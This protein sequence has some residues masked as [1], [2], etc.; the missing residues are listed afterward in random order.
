[1]MKNI[2][3]DNVRLD[4]MGQ[5]PVLI[6]MSVLIGSS[7][8]SICLGYFLKIQEPIMTLSRLKT[9]EIV[10]KKEFEN[11][12]RH[13]YHL[14]EY[15]QQIRILGSHFTSLVKQF[16][17]P[18]NVSILLEE[19][20]QMGII[21]G[22]KFELFAPQK[23]ISQ[24]FYVALPIKISVVGNY[25]QFAMFLSRVAN[26]EH[27]VTIDNLH[28][29][30]FSAEHFKSTTPIDQLMMNITAKIYRCSVC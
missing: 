28:I 10:L 22:L 7:I 2:N 6:K 16:S 19:I 20:S 18:K 27:I 30:R 14:N 9:Q 25:F 17:K 8:L 24:D 5:W 23:E 1:M 26:L 29:K 21:S 15:K 13:L 4:N 3:L 11:K 12:Q